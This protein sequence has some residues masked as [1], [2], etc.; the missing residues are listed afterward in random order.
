MLISWSRVQD[1][2][3]MVIWQLAIKSLTSTVYR[4]TEYWSWYYCNIAI[5]WKRHNMYLALGTDLTVSI[6]ITWQRGV[7][8]PRV[9]PPPPANQPTS[10][11][12][13]WP[14]S[15]PLA[16]P[17]VSPR[18]ASVSRARPL[19]RHLQ[20]PAT[21]PRRPFVFLP[22]PLQPV[23]KRPLQYH[24]I[25]DTYNSSCSCSS[26]RKDC[27]FLFSQN[28][29]VSSADQ[30]ALASASHSDEPGSNLE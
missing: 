22:Y 5:V 7:I 29:S 4:L 18:S 15:P 17:P 28:C 10:R 16:H 8:H 11:L 19:D 30:R 14:P 26:R 23:S 21:P 2:S 20:K 13:R 3:I 12:W 27:P 9:P 25:A 1:L 24:K 6:G